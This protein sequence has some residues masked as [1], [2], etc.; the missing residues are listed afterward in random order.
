MRWKHVHPSTFGYGRASFIPTQGFPPCLL[1]RR[2]T[3][4]HPQ[5]HRSLFQAA[6]LRKDGQGVSAWSTAT[7]L[8]PQTTTT[9][10][11][12]STTSLHGHHASNDDNLTEPVSSL[13]LL[14]DPFYQQVRWRRKDGHRFF[15]KPRPPS[16]KQKR[17]YQRLKRK[18]ELEAQKHG[19]PG[20]KAGEKRQMLREST[21]E[22]LEPLPPSNSSPESLESYNAGDAA[23]ESLVGNMKE[24]IP[25][26][27]PRFLGHRH[28]TLYQR[29]AGTMKTFRRDMD[30]LGG[31]N[32]PM[33][34]QML[35]LSDGGAES[36]AQG[37]QT[38]NLAQSLVSDSALTTDPSEIELPKDK[39]IAL[40]VRAFRDRYG[41]RQ[42]PVGLA[43]ALSHVLQDMGVP[44]SSLGDYS[45]NALMACAKTPNEA[46]KVMDL[47]KQQGHAILPHSWAILVDVHAKAGDYQGCIAVHE[48]MATH[49]LSPVLPSYTSLLAACYKVCANPSLSHAERAQAHKVAWENW[50]EMNIIGIEPD[51]MAFGALLRII[52]TK[53]MPERALSILN[54]MHVRKV[55][56]TTLCFTS[57]LRAVARSHEVAIRFERG[58]RR[59]Q[60]RREQI[61]SHHG[62]LAQEILILA[63]NADVEHDDGFIAALI[64]CAAAAGDVATAKAIYVASQIRRLDQFRTIGD[65]DHLA[66]LRGERVD[67]P[68]DDDHAAPHQLV[69]GGGGGSSNS[70]LST[71]GPSSRERVDENSVRIHNNAVHAFGEREYGKDTRVLTAIARACASAAGKNGIGTMWQ[72]RENEGYLCINSLRLLKTRGVPNYTDTSIPGESRGDYWQEEKDAIEGREHEWG[73]KHG[74]P[75]KGLI[76]EDNPQT[77]IYDLDGEMRDMILDEHGDKKPEF[78]NMNFEDA[79]KLKYGAS[80]RMFLEVKRAK[81]FILGEA[82][83]AKLD[84]GGNSSVPPLS[85]GSP[86]EAN[87]SESDGGTSS[88]IGEFAVSSGVGNGTP[89]GGDEEGLEFNYTTMTW[90]TKSTSSL[91]DSNTMNKNVEV[92]EESMSGTQSQGVEEDTETK[93]YDTPNTSHKSTSV[94]ARLEESTTTAVTPAKDLDDLEQSMFGRIENT[95]GKRPLGGN[96]EVSFSCSEHFFIRHASTLP[97]VRITLRCQDSTDFSLDRRLARV[98]HQ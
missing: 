45:Y 27:I 36:L 49:G 6:F 58:S 59:K 42:S 69:E 44:L 60:M 64:S 83:M 87:S 33:T 48:E 35:K 16:K 76:P 47:M 65:N 21:K 89:V 71:V 15:M 52:A 1:F 97:E 51:A 81:G 62:K 12:S 98:L 9:N 57:A 82:D 2:D 43:K 26:P 53:G 75:Y 78:R 94:V 90:E 28:E 18:Q 63:E 30:A 5:T 93:Y 22:F 46:R 61:A 4:V 31:G 73:R 25:T 95:K 13:R 72:G 84:A 50:K 39:D 14:E 24:G 37:N 66:R 92:E 34:H 10:V 11:G 96:Y 54:E 86:D 20:S 70:G 32:N 38:P 19:A 40:A 17:R 74:R 8:S 91:K 80:D 67:D 7:S 68:V 41:T 79:W 88:G 56:P 85:A 3:K 77:S 55:R 29:V 23:L